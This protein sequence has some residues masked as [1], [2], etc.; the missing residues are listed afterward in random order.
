MKK[1]KASLGKN[2]AKEAKT[3]EKPQKIRVFNYNRNWEK[4]SWAQGWLTKAEY[5]RNDPNQAYCKVCFKT[6]RAQA[7]DLRKHSTVPS[8]DAAMK[9]V[10]INMQKTIVSMCN[11]QH[12]KDEKV[13]DLKIAAFIASHTSIRDIDHLSNILK[14]LYPDFKNF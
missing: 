1:S 9:N 6:L 3:T 7:N 8:H 4:E 11:V 13:R 12:K 2:K 14:S 10:N 5:N